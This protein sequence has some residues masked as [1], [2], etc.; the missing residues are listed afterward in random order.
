MFV[1]KEKPPKN[2]TMQDIDMQLIEVSALNTRK[3]LEAGTEDSSLDDLAKSIAEKGLLSPIIVRAKPTGKYELIAGQ[4]RYLACRKLKWK[5]IPAI[6][7]SDLNDNDAAAIS[8]IEN[9]HRAELNPIDKANALSELLKRYNNDYNKVTKETG[10]GTTTVKRYISLLELPDQLKQ[11]LSTT[12]GP[13]K[14]QALSLLA[15]T[16]KDKGEMLTAYSKISGFTQ[17]VQME[18]IKQSGGDIRKVDDL[19]ELAH[20]GVFKMHICRGVYD[21]AFVQQWIQVVNDT[22]NKRDDSINDARI[23]DIMRLLRKNVEN[24]KEKPK[25][26]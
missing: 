8:L 7:R 24:K 20:E 16:F 21:C 18:I 25:H 5:T 9:V 14:V 4:R 15:K 6:V 2:P 11:K 19:V 26:H 12:E 17:I 3:D 13:A 22:L 23:R 10:I 1:K